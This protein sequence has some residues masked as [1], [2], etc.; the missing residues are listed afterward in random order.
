[1]LSTD[2]GAE[3]GEL[4]GGTINTLFKSGTNR[5]HGS[6]YEYFRDSSFDARNYFDQGSVPPFRRHQFGGSAGGPI[7]KDKTFFFT[8][9]EGFRQ[10][11][12]QSFTTTFPTRMPGR[13]RCPAK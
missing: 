12:G 13:V 5:F 8:N 1:M 3:Y 2:F 4:S 6:A 9:Y 7:R 11:L 10:H